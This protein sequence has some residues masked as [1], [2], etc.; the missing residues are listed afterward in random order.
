MFAM[1]KF[2]D[3]RRMSIPD[4]AIEGTMDRAQRGALLQALIENE[5]RIGAAAAQLRIGRSTTYRLI[6]RFAIPLP[7]SLD[8]GRL[9]SKR[10]A[11]SAG[12]DHVI[13]DGVNYLLVSSE[14]AVA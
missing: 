13:F 9:R 12:N 4:W 1:V 2:D 8:R 7:A 10:R 6:Q 14:G 3:G 5:Y 11:R